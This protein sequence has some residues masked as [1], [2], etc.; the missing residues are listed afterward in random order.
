MTKV[1]RR[2][3]KV[4]SLVWSCNCDGI[5]QSLEVKLISTLLVNYVYFNQS[6]FAIAT[7]HIYLHRFKLEVRCLQEML[8]LGRNNIY[9]IQKMRPALNIRS[10]FE[11][12]YLYWPLE[13]SVENKMR[14]Y[15]SLE[16]VIDLGHI[17]MSETRLRLGHKYSNSFI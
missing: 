5:Q 2:T 11:F 17:F 12:E 6:W 4:F 1:A 15:N 16:N 7:L 9:I 10:L 8:S 3:K 13:F 14:S